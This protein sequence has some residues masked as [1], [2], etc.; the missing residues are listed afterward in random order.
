MSTNCLR[1]LVRSGLA[2]LAAALLSA[3]AAA[4]PI[5]STFSVQGANFPGDFLPTG[6]MTFNATGDLTPEVAPGSSGALL[7]A[8]QYFA[9]GGAN[10]GDLLGFQFQFAGTLPSPDPFGFLISGLDVGMPGFQLLSASIAFDFGVSQFPQTGITLLVTAFDLGGANFAFVAPI[11]W[12][13]IFNASNPPA[14]AGPTGI[15]TTFFVEI[16]QVPEPP[17]LA[18]MLAGGLG[19]GVWLRRRRAR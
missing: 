15:V 3:T 9:G 7:V 10:G 18:L 16:A 8:E 12:G 17:I 2:V 14:G 5:G 4:A 13:D 6:T 11:G 1:A 19:I